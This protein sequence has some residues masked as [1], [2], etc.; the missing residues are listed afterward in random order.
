MNMINR[1]VTVSPK[2]FFFT[3]FD[4]SSENG[5][6]KWNRIMAMATNCQ[7]WSSRVRNQ[8]ISSGRL[9][10]QMIR[11]CENETYAQN[12]VNASMSLPMSC[13]MSFLKNHAIGSYFESRMQI[14]AVNESAE[15]ACAE[16]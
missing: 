11:N 9:P 10:A 8:L 15:S 3:S 12:M 13:M 5:I 1:A 4:S 14:A 16:R 2:R 6:T 7:P